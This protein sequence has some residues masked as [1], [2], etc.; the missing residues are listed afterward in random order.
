MFSNYCNFAFCILHFC[1]YRFPADKALKEK[2]EQQ[3]KAEFVDLSLP[4]YSYIC[5][6]HF[7]ADC[8][9]FAGLCKNLRLKQGS[10]PSIFSSLEPNNL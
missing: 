6:S 4:K 5:S 9:Y 7:K 8:F 1:V 10:Y 2:W 3:L